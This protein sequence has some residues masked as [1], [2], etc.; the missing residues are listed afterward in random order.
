M[1]PCVHVH[2]THLL[3]ATHAHTCARTPMHAAS[4]VHQLFVARM[5]HGRMWGVQQAGQPQALSA[6]TRVSHPCMTL[7]TDRV[8]R[9]SPIS[10]PQTP[11]SGGWGAVGKC[12]IPSSSSERGWKPPSVGLAHTVLSP[13]PQ[14]QSFPGHRQPMHPQTPPAEQG[15]Q[16]PHTPC[17]AAAHGK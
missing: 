16:C 2:P 15:P 13:S 11:F 12:Q 5:G 3:I 17:P 7:S 14:N 8:G 4:H 10:C 6:M 9:A 1:P